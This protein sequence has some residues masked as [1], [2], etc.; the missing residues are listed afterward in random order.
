MLPFILDSVFSTARTDI[1]DFQVIL[2]PKW[3]WIF[4]F[5]QE[6][7]LLFHALE[8]LSQIIPFLVSF[9]KLCIWHNHVCSQLTLEIQILSVFVWLKLLY[10]ILM[11]KSPMWLEFQSIS[12]TFYLVNYFISSLLLISMCTF[13]IE[14]YQP[15]PL[16]ADQKGFCTLSEIM[17]SQLLSMFHRISL[18]IFS[19]MH[20]IFVFHYSYP[21]SLRRVLGDSCEKTLAM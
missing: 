17:F 19:F 12:I 4:S 18:H 14:L 10:V 3:I 20:E 11:E 7:W 16:R 5:Y 8:V 9:W 6:T 13:W 2:V 21:C 15:T 1:C